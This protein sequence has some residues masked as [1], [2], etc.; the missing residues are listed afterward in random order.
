MFK[1]HT[2]QLHR[3]VSPYAPFHEP[4]HAASRFDA[5]TGQGTILKMPTGTKLEHPVLDGSTEG[6]VA[7]SA[8]IN[9]FRGLPDPALGEWRYGHE[10]IHTHGHA[11]FH[12]H[13]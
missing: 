13:A 7:Q 5:G 9:P 4:P 12:W 10:H 8:T 2:R 6:R 3:P 11:H 1:L